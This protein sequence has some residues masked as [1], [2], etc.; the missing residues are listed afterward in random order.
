[1]LGIIKTKNSV[2]SGGQGVRILFKAK[3]TKIQGCFFLVILLSFSISNA[4]TTDTIYAKMV[5]PGKFDCFL[6]GA[7]ESV[8]IFSGPYCKVISI[9]G[10]SAVISGGGGGFYFFHRFFAI[11]ELFGMWEPKPL[12]ESADFK[13]SQ[14]GGIIG[15]ELFQQKKIHCAVQSFIGTSSLE[16]FNINGVKDTGSLSA[17]LLEPAI[18]AEFNIAPNFRG[19]MG[20]GY[21]INFGK[22]EHHGLT[23]ADLNGYSLNFGFKF[24]GL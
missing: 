18:D 19:T 4:L 21:R 11:Y 24:G 3:R 6:K 22:N 9:A 15:F 23:A 17:F 14:N 10:T 7:D 5:E 1:M 2:N 8:G 16:F 20:F 12:D 13:F